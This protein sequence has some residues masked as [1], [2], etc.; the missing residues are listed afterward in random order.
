MAYFPPLLLL[1]WLAP[2]IAANSSE[3]AVNERL[4]FSRAEMEAQWQVDC[5]GAWNRLQTT[6]KEGTSKDRCGIS[7]QA[8]RELQLCAFIYQPPGQE[9][10]ADCPDYQGA[11][12][13]L[14]NCSEL[15]TWLEKS[16][17]CPEGQ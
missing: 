2:A 10:H 4:P 9:P 5:T 1:L 6:A 11:T 7:T 8:A 3:D 15:L 17:H 13:L 12:Q 14:K 16:S